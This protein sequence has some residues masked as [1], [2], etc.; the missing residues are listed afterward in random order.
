MGYKP[1]GYEDVERPRRIREDFSETKWALRY[2]LKK[3]KIMVIRIIYVYRVFIWQLLAITSRR[4]SAAYYVG[5][6]LCGPKYDKRGDRKWQPII[7]T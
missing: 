4:K 2:T 7:V 6:R 1:D 3:Y 5:S